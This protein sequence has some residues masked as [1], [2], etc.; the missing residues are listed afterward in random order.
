MRFI[1]QNDIKEIRRRRC[2]A[3]DTRTDA[4]WR[5]DDDVVKGERL[6]LC[7]IL[8]SVFDSMHGRC[9]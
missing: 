2:D 7:G 9:R 8:N 3:R 1:Y 4:V 6:P 5:T